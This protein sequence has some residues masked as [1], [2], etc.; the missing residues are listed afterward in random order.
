MALLFHRVLQFCNTEV[1]QETKTTNK[2]LD[3]FYIIIALEN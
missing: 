1:L 3:D 2:P